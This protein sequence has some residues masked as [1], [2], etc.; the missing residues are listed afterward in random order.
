MEKFPRH[1]FNGT[2]QNKQAKHIMKQQPEGYIVLVHDFSEHYRCSTQ[3]EIQSCYF[4]KT[5]VSLHVTIIHRY[6]LKEDGKVDTGAVIQ[7]QFFVITSDLKHEHHFT[8]H[9]QKLIIDYLRGIKCPIKTIH[10][11]TDVCQYI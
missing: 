6:E 11:F 3:K 7:E 4:Q 5:E 2:W 8:Y 9:V 10:E 1:Q